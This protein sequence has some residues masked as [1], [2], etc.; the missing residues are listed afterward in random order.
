MYIAPPNSIFVTSDTEIDVMLKVELAE[1]IK[2]PLFK[3]E[4][5]EKVEL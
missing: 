3:L 4:I 1:Y 5:P 2:P